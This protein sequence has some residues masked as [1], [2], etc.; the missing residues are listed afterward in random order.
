VLL[1]IDHLVVAVDDPDVAVEELCVA[2]GVAPG[3]GGTH[4]SLGTRNQLIWLG[5]TFVEFLGITDPGLAAKSWLGAPALAALATGPALVGWAIA[6]DDLEDDAVTL[7]TAGAEL[8]PTTAGERR[9]PDGAMVRW[10]LALP[11]GIDLSHPFLIKHAAD[12]AEWTDRD[13]Q[14]R[15]AAPGRVAA[16]H[17]P[18]GRVFG[19]PPGAH[20]QP[21]AVGPQHVV[22]HHDGTPLIE[23]SGL[24]RPRRI[25]LFGCSWAFV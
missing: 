12:S 23:L 5:D 18:V 20:D 21:I 3:G 10:Q 2:L 1:G 17:L 6:T 15:V 14:G 9:R 8:G 11:P 22:I 13:R 24:G 4:P 16:L 7:R 19:F 25:S